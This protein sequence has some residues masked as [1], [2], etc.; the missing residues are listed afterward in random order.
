MWSG[1]HRA[2]LDDICMMI[3]TNALEV[4]GIAQDLLA[5]RIHHLGETDSSPGH[6]FSSHLGSGAAK[7]VAGLASLRTRIAS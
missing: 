6:W 7:E 4:L 2:T 1:R 5:R 3:P